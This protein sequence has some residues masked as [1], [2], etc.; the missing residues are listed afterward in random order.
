MRAGQA[1][2]AAHVG[3]D[4]PAIPLQRKEGTNMNITDI[5]ALA[6]AGYKPSDVKEI[7]EL[8]SSKEESPKEEEKDQDKKTEQHEDGKEQP[9]EAPKKSTDDSSKDANAIDRYKK[10]IEELEAQLQKIQSDNVHKDNKDK[11]NE[12]SDED[13]LNDITRAFM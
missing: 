3:L 7:I 9:D 1:L 4:R 5:I 8:A 2:G 10:K 11:D 12:R 6:K 13:I